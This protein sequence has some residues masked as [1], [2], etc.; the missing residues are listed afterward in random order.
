MSLWVLVA[1]FVFLA[2]TIEVVTGFGS[3][4][5][6][7][8]LS[9]LFLPIDALL[10][11]LV[12]LNICMTGYLVARHRRHIHG[13]TLLRLIL[14]LMVLGTLIGYGLRPWLSDTFMQLLLGALVVWFAG[15]QL[16]QLRRGVIAVRHHPAWTRGWML[17]A[18][19]T[20]GL[21]ASGGP[22]L[23][24]AL[25]GVE[26]DKARFRATLVTV[27]LVLNGLLTLVFALDGTLVSA[28]PRVAAL[29]PVL[30]LGVVVGEWLHGRVNEAVFR[31]LVL[32]LLLITGVILIL[33]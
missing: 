18:G 8:S 13:P 23:V 17:A 22:L 14:P 2:Y 20:H 9:A 10:P 5:I 26:L 15:R 4:V 27:W 30:V 3:I 1:L 12:P 32:V 31:Q 6:A 7:L 21:F 29:L 24:Y 16:W 33:P 25:T 28:L 11:V 19:V